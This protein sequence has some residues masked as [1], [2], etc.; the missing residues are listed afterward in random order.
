[1]LYT[2]N[3]AKPTTG[4]E[5]MCRCNREIIIHSI[6]S[7]IALPPFTLCSPPSLSAA[8]L[9]IHKRKPE[10]RNH[11]CEWCR[12]SALRGEE[13]ERERSWCDESWVQLL[14]DSLCACCSIFKSWEQ[15][16]LL[17]P[18][19]PHPNPPRWRLCVPLPRLPLSDQNTH[20]IPHRTL[21]TEHYT[22]QKQGTK[23]FWMKI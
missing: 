20:I 23:L 17:P 10:N 19:R 12:Q 21:T 2:I 15:F 7:L 18:P 9:F 16:I 6:T 22:I 1:M 5:S 13:R 14:E 4:H 11:V 3:L 8:S